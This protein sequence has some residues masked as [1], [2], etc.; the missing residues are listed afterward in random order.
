MP[1]M[2]T[3]ASRSVF[4]VGMLAVFVAAQLC[5]G[6]LTY[7]GVSTFG[8][9]IEANPIVAWYIGVL[10]AGM[11]LFALK[12]LAITCA[13]LLYRFAHYRTIGA[14]TIIYLTMAVHPWVNL[15]L[16]H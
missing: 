15:L 9:E 14:L 10:G 8:H 12:T 16:S 5:D 13:L 6:V 2:M 11:A 3:G 1:R 7:V 4:G